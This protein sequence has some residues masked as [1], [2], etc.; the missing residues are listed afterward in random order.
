MTWIVGT[1]CPFGYSVG[2]SDIRVSFPDGSEGDCLRKIY[3]VGR[4]LAAGFAGSVAIGF[5]M[6]RTLTRLL[7]NPNKGEAWIPEAVAQW[8]PSDAISVFERYSDTE[9]SRGSQLM[10]FGVHPT[11]DNGEPAG[12]PKSSVYRFSDPHFQPEESQG[13]EVVSIGSGSQVAS[14]KEVLRE[15]SDGGENFQF[16]MMGSK[17]IATRLAISLTAALQAKPQPGISPHLHLCVV[18]RGDIELGTNDHDEFDSDGSPKP[19]RMPQVATSYEEIVKLCQSR[20]VTAEG[21]SC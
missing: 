15:L 7:H 19:F 17:G 6:V 16:V 11:E 14:Y 21:A 13:I 4:F 3:P 20:G 9:R 18:T 5:D 12:W 2:L 10:L 8:W 1:A